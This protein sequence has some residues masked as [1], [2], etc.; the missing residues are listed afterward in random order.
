MST[1]PNLVSTA[2]KKNYSILKL[3]ISTCKERL[4]LC[5]N[6]LLFIIFLL[7]MPFVNGVENLV[8]DDLSIYEIIIVLT[9]MWARSLLII[10]EEKKME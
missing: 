6:L 10:K 8:N 2:K 7:F 5:V 1:S 4:Y 3:R 9:D